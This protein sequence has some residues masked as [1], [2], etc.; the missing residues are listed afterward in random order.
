MNCVVVVMVVVMV[1]VVV[2]MVCSF[3]LL[4]GDAASNDNDT[5]VDAMRKYPL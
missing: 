4:A 2:V 5:V 1:V 3:C